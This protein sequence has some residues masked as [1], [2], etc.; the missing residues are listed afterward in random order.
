MSYTP[1]ILFELIRC[2]MNATCISNETKEQLTPEVLKE[3]YILSKSHDIAHI[4][5]AALDKIGLIGKDELS[6]LYRKQSM[7]AMW[8]YANI[9]Y[10]LQEICC[11]LEESKIQ[12]VPL[13][14]AVIR[15]YYPEPWM[16][17]S[18][19]IDILVHNEDIERAVEILTREAGYRVHLRN[20]HD[21]S[22]FS[23]GGVHLELHFS[24]KENMERL[25]SVLESVWGYA[26][27]TDETP[28]HMQLT[29][30]F[31]IFHVLAHMAYHFSSGGCG[32]RPVLDFWLIRWNI[33][34][35]SEKLMALLEKAELK[36]F[37]ESVSRLSQVWFSGTAHDELTLEMQE[38][39]LS[40]GVYGSQENRISVKQH[41]LNGKLKYVFYRIFMPYSELK[42][43]YPILKKHRFLTPLY[44]VRW[45]FGL[46][47]KGGVKRSINELRVNHNMS[48]DKVAKTA[49]LFEQIGL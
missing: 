2:E 49:E 39:I 46:I 21:I 17:T 8:R 12:F 26:V 48:E 7:T 15:K 20:Y 1:D 33:E 43:Q 42:N 9:D 25:D 38:F 27:R 6:E 24:I 31:L 32:I 47:F 16:R 34:F 3:L 23:E 5:S 44:E 29:N 45:W 13:K 30:E 19:D 22:L 36:N 41:K 14:G 28:Y 37:Y 40:G 35:D 10:E 11:T 18:C 4:V